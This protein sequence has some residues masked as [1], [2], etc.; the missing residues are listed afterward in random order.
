MDTAIT[1]NP[2]A[3]PEV[4]IKMVQLAEELGFDY[5]YIGDQGLIRDVYTT[6]TIV[7]QA[8]RRIRL[9]PG[10][11]HPYTRHPVAAAVAI[12]SLD[13]I[14]GGRAFYGL[15]AGGSRT[16]E[17]LRMKR[18]APLQKCRE[19][20]EI[21]RLLW[22]GEAVTYEGKY[23]QLAE[24]RLAFPA[25]S[26]IELHWAAR[27]AKML[28]LGGELADVVM[29]HGIPDFEL[30]DV[31]AHVQAGAARASRSVRL[32][33][34][35]APAFDEVSR[36]SA[37]ARTAYR[38]LDSEASVRERLGI[39]PEL[40]AE[41]RRLVTTSGPPAA[42]H[43]VNDEV[44]GHYVISGEPKECAAKLRRLCATHR[45]DGLSIEISDLRQA[46]SVLRFATEVIA[47]I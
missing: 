46:E 35:V 19:A 39:S 20:A 11:T 4:V 17:P 7:A 28:S 23:F 37:R 12:A 18:A 32:Y 40:I 21:A 41:I 1:F 24:A 33:Y 42:A 9:G 47:Q 16:L 31:V 27:G 34:A 2:E 26:D 38:L 13:E 43:L 44:L 8:T 3:S 36:A 6:L 22:Q 45:L 5:C 25:R 15:G 30:A 29:L 14:S 10:V